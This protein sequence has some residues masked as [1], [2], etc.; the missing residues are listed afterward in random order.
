MS[1]K[2]E[3]ELSS[4]RRLIDRSKNF[5]DFK[6][7]VKNLKCHKC[8]KV[9]DGVLFLDKKSFVVTDT[10]EFMLFS[11]GVSCDACIGSKY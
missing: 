3:P 4:V 7:E 8:G 11:E 9:F 6:F 10:W 5:G 2:K 1:Y